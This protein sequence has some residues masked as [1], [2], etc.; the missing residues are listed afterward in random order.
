MLRVINLATVVFWT[1]TPLFGAVLIV[2]WLRFGWVAG[3][4]A[5]QVAVCAGLLGW[6]S[7]AS[8][9]KRGKG[10]EMIMYIIAIYFALNAVLFSLLYLL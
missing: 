8:S 3:L 5:I 6:H 4:L 9:G 1:C 7:Q 2:P 10:V